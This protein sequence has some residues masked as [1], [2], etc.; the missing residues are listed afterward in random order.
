ME[1]DDFLIYIASEKGLSHNTIEAY[2]HDTRKF[3]AFVKEQHINSFIEITQEHLLS[4]LKTLKG[5]NF[6]S[7][8][9]CR[10][11]IACK[12]LF[13]F[14]KREGVITNDPTC[15]LDT[16][17]LWQTLPDVLSIK[18][19]ELMLSYCDAE[20]E[21]GCRDLSIIELLYSSGLRVSELCNLSISDVDDEFVKVMGKGRKER[22]VPLGKKAIDAIDHYLI[23]FGDQKTENRHEKLF[24]KSGAK[25]IDRITVWKIIK[26]YAKKAGI[27]KNVSPHTLRHSFATHL[28]DNGADLRVIQEMLGHA[29]IGTTDRYTHVSRT[30]LQ[31]SFDTFHPRK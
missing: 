30:R 12:V 3:I 18:E 29:S 20:T 27:L 7:S 9:I 1:I 28:L 14:L 22:V 8:T 11:L 25:P 26:K 24:V 6:K 16:P 15:Y 5:K 10:N 21:D 13:K 17:K 2:S 23:H 4:F 19:I 31:E